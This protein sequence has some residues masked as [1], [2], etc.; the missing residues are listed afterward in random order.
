MLTQRG[1][2]LAGTLKQDMGGGLFRNQ[3][4]LGMALHRRMCRKWSEVRGPSARDIIG[5][6]HEQ[7]FST[8][9]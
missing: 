5:S 7:S 2:W 9:L 4:Q 8:R 6:T 1:R 3:K